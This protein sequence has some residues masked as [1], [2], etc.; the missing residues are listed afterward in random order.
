M[1][2]QILRT[3][4]LA[5][6]FLL[7]GNEHR[8]G[9]VNGYTIRQGTGASGTD[10][11]TILV[12]EH[13]AKLGHRVVIS[14]PNGGEPGTCVNGVT[15]TNM[16]FDTI[17]D[18]TF[19]VLVNTLWFE[20][21]H[22]LPITVTRAFVSWCHCPYLYGFDPIKRMITAGGLRYGIIHLSEWSKKM[23]TRIA[24]DLAHD[25]TECV[26]P[27]PIPVDMCQQ[28]LREVDA[29]L[30]VKR[31]HDFIF[32]A[33]WIRGGQMACDII[34]KLPEHGWDN[35]RMMSCSYLMHRP[36][37]RHIVPMGSLGKMDVLRA[38][39]R[40]GYFL[41]PLVNKP[42][43]QMHKDTFACVVAEACALG[44]IVVTYPVAALPETYEDTCVWLQIPESCLDKH[45]IVNS[46]LSTDENL[47]E[48]KH[49]FDTLN[50]LDKDPERKA[51]I[52]ES[53][54]QRVFDLY[55]AERIGNMWQDYLENLVL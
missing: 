6:V 22:T 45:E 55:N 52:R 41:Y 43:A 19:D 29:G 31:E 37:D 28:V 47:L 26:I 21:F 16:Q 44:A 42:N 32:H 14:A 35:P 40:C 27:N 1:A 11:T 13:L 5:I 39:A 46:T 24:H 53:A 3:G 7:T 18:R 15:Y 10:W 51:R 4:I 8:N 23:N 38:I 33:E 54:R 17:A 49:I 20:D 48:T 12:A 36:H 9:A 25:V 2:S 50:A 34:G 30:V